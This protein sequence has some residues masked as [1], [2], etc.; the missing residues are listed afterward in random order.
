MNRPYDCPGRPPGD[1]PEVYARISKGAELTGTN[2]SI[3]LVVVRVHSMIPA[4]PTSLGTRYPGSLQRTIPGGHIGG[5][6]PVPIP[7]TDVKP[8]GADDTRK[9]KVGRCQDFSKQRT[10]RQSA[11][12]VVWKSPPAATCFPPGEAAERS[13]SLSHR[14]NRIGKFS[15]T[16]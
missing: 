4:L 9:G 15:P 3:G 1:R 7:N 8:T 14:S 10:Q 11:G 16:R 12:C 2:R 13:E 6:T 5:V